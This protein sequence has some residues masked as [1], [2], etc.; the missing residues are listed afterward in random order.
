MRTTTRVRARPLPKVTKGCID[1]GKQPCNIGRVDGR[2][3]ADIPRS[4]PACLIPAAK[5]D[6]DVSDEPGQQPEHGE[7]IMARKTP[8]EPTTN[9]EVRQVSFTPEALQSVIAQAV[10]LALASQKAAPQAVARDGQ[11]VRSMQNHVKTIKAFKRAGF[12]DAV[13]HVNVKTFNRWM[14]EGRRPVEGCH[15][16]K[17]A[18]LR[19]FHLSQTRAITI[20][21]REAMQAQSDA[22]VARHEGKVVPIGTGAPQ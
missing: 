15:S 12:A 9:N 22:A 11:T 2:M 18:N 8:D 3:A 10:A 5:Q 4:E 14:A 21:E 17:V 20:E 7:C 6:A 16:I 19:L 1:N 13:P